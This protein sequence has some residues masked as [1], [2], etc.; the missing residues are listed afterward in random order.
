M[1]RPTSLRA[2]C[3]DQVA[4]FRTGLAGLCLLFALVGCDSTTPQ[5]HL[6]NAAALREQGKVN[7][8][9]I[10]LKNALQK[11]SAFAAGR[12]AL[13]NVYLDTGDYPSALKEMERALDL[14]SNSSEVALGLGR[15]KLGLGRVQEV[16]GDLSA[17]TD[18]DIDLDLLLAEAYLSQNNVENARPLFEKGRE[19]GAGLAGL[20]AIAWNEGDIERAERLFAQATDKEPTNPQFWLRRAELALSQT[21]HEEAMS[22]FGEATKYPTGRV[23]GEIGEVRTLLASNDIEGA[24]VAIDEV[25]A[26]APK[27]PL[28]R[29]LEGLIR[30]QTD[31]LASA[32]SAL[33]EVQRQYP[34]HGPSL[35][36]MGLVKYR[37]GQLAQAEENLARFLTTNESSE[38]ARKLLAT[39][40]YERGEPQAAYETLQPLENVSRDPQILAMLGTTLMQL[41]DSAAAT[42]YLERAVELAPDGAAFR[43][44]LALSL[45]SAGDEER[46]RAELSAAIETDGAQFQSDYLLAMIQLREGNLAKAKTS[47]ERIIEKSPDSPVGP[48]LMGAIAI[49]ENQLEAATGHFRQALKVD[50]SFSPARNNLTRL[51]ERQG[52][53]EGAEKI[54]MD[55]IG[56]D[57]SDDVALLGL[58]DL[59]ARNQRSEDAIAFA[60]RATLVDAKNPRAR[61]AL[62]RLYVLTGENEK[63]LESVSDGLR[64]DPENADLKLL[65]AELGLRA[66]DR[67]A[68]RRD[69]NDLQAM[70]VD[71]PDNARLA[72]VLGRLHAQTGNMDLARSNFQRVIQ[73]SDGK[74]AEAL[75][76]LGRLN[77]SQREFKEAQKQV[78]QLG[79]LEAPE[80]VGAAKLLAADISMA[81]GDEAK[82]ERLYGDLHKVGQREGT[83][84]LAGINLR[85]NDTDQGIE[86]LQSWLRSNP[87]DQAARI[88]LS[89][90][91]LQDDQSMKAIG[92]YEKLISTGNPV[93]LNNLAWLY[94]EQG[95]SRAEAT[96]AKAFAAAPDN[97]DVADTY[98]WILLQAGKVRKAI[99]VMSGTIT[100]DTTNPTALYHMSVARYRAGEPIQARRLLQRALEAPRFPER[101][102]AQALLDDIGEG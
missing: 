58:A 24:S 33:R 67:T 9:I 12:I 56:A 53:I 59:L 7:E 81:Q 68:A 90:A 2:T 6:D 60:E 50:P 20:A 69:L 64:H 72:Y 85:R 5:G 51:L 98:G 25:L 22:A 97:P 37:Q 46:A 45:L 36:L 3:F 26:I 94:M 102:D 89:G 15:A 16:I 91:L 40:Q 101:D 74:N 52:D 62:A 10:E 95:D 84:R 13:G 34:S 30:Y 19:K 63:A 93:V 75:L 55:R 41:G 82:A 87:T 100:Q 42:E 57:S 29:Y 23:L 44:Q 79:K 8:A 1:I 28:A 65:R 83:L 99:D 32:E 4:S 47:V 35:Y 49:S 48:N 39:V 11:D 70:L 61:L 18:R 96:G 78:D 76:A 88:L 54:F 38:S 17:R 27:Y 66:G 43:N 14:G 73:L 21:K 92:E 31:D 71:R 80:I 86:L 77:L